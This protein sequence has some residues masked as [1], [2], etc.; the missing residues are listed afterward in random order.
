MQAPQAS[1]YAWHVDMHGVKALPARLL[2][3]LRNTQKIC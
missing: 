1:K 3:S 2:R